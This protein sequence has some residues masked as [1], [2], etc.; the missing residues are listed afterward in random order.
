M[1]RFMLVKKARYL[2]VSHT[3][4]ILLAVKHPGCVRPD[5]PV[6]NGEDREAER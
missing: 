3:F 1:L 2:P 4:T 6:E 5:E